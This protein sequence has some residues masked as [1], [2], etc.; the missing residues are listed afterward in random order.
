MS[1]VFD[2]PPTARRSAGLLDLL[3]DADYRAV[4]DS[5]VFAFDTDPAVVREYLPAPLEEDEPGLVLL[6][7]SERYIY[8]AKQ[9][10]EFVS[11]DRAHYN[12]VIIKVP[13][14]Y[15]GERIYYSLFAWTDVDWMAYMARHSGGPLKMGHLGF[16]RFHPSDV[17]YNQPR[18]GVRIAAR[19]DGYDPIARATVRLERPYDYEELPFDLGPHY[20]PKSLSYRYVLDVVENKPVLNDLCMHWAEGMNIGGVWG[21]PAEVEFFKAEN[22]E[23]DRFQPRSVRGAYFFSV[24]RGQGTQRRAV[25]HRF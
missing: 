3:H 16:T 11:P 20:F 21:G 6:W 10:T 18:E 2:F 19:L 25:I 15:N 17:Q 12:E 1:N 13:C 5:V 23:M 22:E 9:Q 24:Q 7:F 4:G 14:R 8:T